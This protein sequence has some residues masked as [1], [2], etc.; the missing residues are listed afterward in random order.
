MSRLADLQRFYQ[1]LDGLEKEVGG[2]RVL[3]DCD[4]R[5][6]WPGRGVY[7]FFEP[8][9]V[10]EAT[11]AGLRVVRVG[12]HALMTGAGTTLWG[13]LAQHRGVQRSGSGNHRGSIFRLLVGQAL[14]ARD[15][16]AAETWGSR[17]DAGKAGQRIGLSGHQVRE[18]ERPVEHAVSA[19]LGA[20]P[21]LWVSVDDPP[22]PDSW[23]GFIE[24]NAIA[25]LSN[26][27]K[28][29]LD[30]ASAGWLGHFSDRPNV[31]ESGLWNNNH[32]AEAYDPDFLDVFEALAEKT[33]RDA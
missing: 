11:G 5:I 12:T 23:R 22:G 4:A 3:R 10:R 17:S 32:V 16:L 8:G 21:L 9:E 24:R 15:G 27:G 7:F 14:I 28:T 2:K 30:P 29:T 20:M 25:L 6:G 31:R 33:A 13:R 18:Q 19:V 26:L 1:I